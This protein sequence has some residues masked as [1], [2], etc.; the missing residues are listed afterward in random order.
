MKCKSNVMKADVNVPFQEQLTKVATWRADREVVG[1]VVTKPG[2][3]VR[4]VWNGRR[5]QRDK[6][7][8]VGYLPPHRYACIYV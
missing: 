3:S 6:P 4:E 8:L 1:Q 2:A 5:L 7:V